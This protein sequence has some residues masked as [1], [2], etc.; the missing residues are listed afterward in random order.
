MA[1]LPPSEVKKILLDRPGKEIIEAA[2]TMHKKLSVHINGI[3]LAS[4]LDQIETYEKPEQAMLRKK[5]ARSNT[6]LFA[7][8]GRPID[9]IFSARGGSRYFPDLPEQIARELD[10]RLLDV[11]HGYSS[12]KWIET[13][14]K[15]R[16]LDDPMGLIFMEVDKNDTYPTYKAI[17]DIWDYKMNGRKLD[18]VVFRTE[19]KEIFRVVDDNFDVLYK[20]EGD[21]VKRVP[22]SSYPNYFGYVPGIIIS[23]IPKSGVKNLFASPFDTIVEV[24]D[25]YLRDG[26]IRNIY[27]FKHGFPKSWKYREMCGDCKGTGA[28]GARTCS[29]CNGTGKKLDS[30][31]SEVMVLDWPTQND[32]VIAPDVAGYITPDLDYLKY[33]RDEQETL[34]AIMYRTQWDT[35]QVSQKM[36]GEESTAAGRFIDAQ[37]I[38]DRLN[39]YAD[40]AASTEKFIIDAIG[41]FHFQKSYKGCWV[42]YGRRFMVEGPDVIWRKYEQ[43]RKMGAPLS[44]LNEHLTEYYESKFQSN[45]IELAKYLKMMRIEPFVHLTVKE[46]FEVV[47]PDEFARKV[48]FSEWCTTIKEMDWI[49]KSDQVLKDDL[50]SFALARYEEPESKDKK[51]S[52]ETDPNNLMGEGGEDNED[53][54]ETSNTKNPDGT[55]A[56]A[57]TASV[58]K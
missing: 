50:T 47:S 42:S 24:A 45:P 58:D 46:A 31:V 55:L 29:T 6:D 12:K 7:R 32:Q 23:D 14:W 30:S 56:G 15:P 48:Y 27:K 13:F 53:K 38:N 51:E 4:Y 49:T 43:A 11:E 17:T 41:Q 28:I 33:S 22:N 5:Y 34:E 10:S 8:I 40:A 19:D 16:Y 54:G 25:E 36:N 1:T 26:S 21:T 2:E 35:Y 57:S 20:K 37:P 39:A 52:P 9:K 44:T 3:G 18:W